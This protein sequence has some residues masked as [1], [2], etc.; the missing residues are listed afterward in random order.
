ML[1]EGQTEEA[2]VNLLLA[3]HLAD[4][5]LLAIPIIVATKR[6][7]AGGKERGGVSS[8]R[9]V[10]GDIRRLLGDSNAI[11]VT[12]MIDLYGLPRDWPGIELAPSEPFQRVRYLESAMAAAIG[13]GR[14]VPYLS[15]H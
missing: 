14:F 8:W 15:L 4:Y 1:A 10:E 12:T 6:P 2:F 9:Q 3:P 7:A 11:G 5:D 13:N